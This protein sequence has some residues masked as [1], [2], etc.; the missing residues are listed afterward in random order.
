MRTHTCKPKRRPHCKPQNRSGSLLIEALLAAAFLTVCLT[1]FAHQLKSQSEFDRFITDR[2]R[3]QLAVKN[4]AQLLRRVPYDQ[5]ESKLDAIGEQTGFTFTINPFD[6]D[7]VKGK[8]IVIE[9]NSG[10][11]PVRYHCWKLEAEQ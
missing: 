11:A 3:Q 10:Q 4:S 8:H 9:D 6:S 2:L 5:V 7:G 1:V